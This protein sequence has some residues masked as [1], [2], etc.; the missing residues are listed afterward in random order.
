MIKKIISVN[1]TKPQKR[2]FCQT[3]LSRVDLAQKS[4]LYKV[5]AFDLSNFRADLPGLYNNSYTVESLVDNI[6]TLYD[7]YFYPTAIV[8]MALIQD[9]MVSDVINSNN[10]ALERTIDDWAV[11]D[12]NS[13]TA[14]LLKEKPGTIYS[15]A[16]VSGMWVSDFRKIAPDFDKVLS[17][18]NL[19]EKQLALNEGYLP[20][21]ESGNTNM[22]LLRKEQVV[23]AD[24]ETIVASG[25]LAPLRTN[26]KVKGALFIG[27]NAFHLYTYTA[28]NILG[29]NDIPNLQLLVNHASLTVDKL[30]REQVNL[31]GE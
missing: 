14:Q 28:Q 26:N 22:D 15:F 9:N 6:R 10:T 30:L 16:D 20:F 19:D 13:I 7:T 24:A 12:N 4:L 29:L 25:I 27:T 8:S 1:D 18:Q 2:E 3:D 23:N 31:S 17:I 5:P 11:N 21:D